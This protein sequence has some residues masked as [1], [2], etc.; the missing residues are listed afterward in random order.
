M[1][2]LAIPGRKKLR[3]EN[4]VFDLNGTLA[5]DGKIN[6]ETAKRVRRLA[7]RF[8]VYV[9]TAGSHGR[10]E[11]V[12]EI[13]GVEIRHI[14]PGMEAEQ[15]RDFVKALGSE[16]T[17]AIGNGSNDFLMLEKAVL[18]I[19]IVGPEG[20]ATEALSAADILIGD[21][22]LALDLFLKPKRVL[23]TWRR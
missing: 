4:L 19:A 17:A 16:R 7:E 22:N 13:L 3:I 5:M 10:L 6:P 9:L 23:A 14:E 2:E 8:K 11:E 18:G 20:S 21:I 15:K 12:R 1:L